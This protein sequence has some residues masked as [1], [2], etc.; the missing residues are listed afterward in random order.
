LCDWETA[1][2]PLFSTL[3]QSKD[4]CG[5][6]ADAMRHERYA[7]VRSM[8]QGEGETNPFRRILKKTYVSSGTDPTE[9]NVPFVHDSSPSIA[10]SDEFPEAGGI[11][12]GCLGGNGDISV[13]RFCVMWRNEF[14]G[15]RDVPP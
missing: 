2:I 9:E 5:E 6:V 14:H 10:F 7:N 15:V 4:I 8:G 3:R 12:D 13:C 1:N 11:S